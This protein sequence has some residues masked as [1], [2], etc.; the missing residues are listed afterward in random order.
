MGKTLPPKRTKGGVKSSHRFT[1]RQN[2]WAR[3]ARVTLQLVVLFFVFAFPAFAQA[4]LETLSQKISSGSVEQK[5]DAL[6]QLRNLHTEE[7]SRVAAPAVRDPN[8]MV[9]A[10]AA[11]SVI[12]LPKP[13]AVA[14]LLPLLKDKAPFVR[15]E[16]AFALG[17][18]GDPQN[19]QG[20]EKEDVIASALRLLLE[21]DKDP[22]V[23]AAAAVAMGK[24][25]GLKS[26]WYLYFFLQSSPKGTAN[27][28]IRRSAV[29]SIGTVAERLRANADILPAP[30]REIQ[31]EN[32]V[33]MDFSQGFRSFGS[34]SRLLTD[35]LQD[36]SEP[37]DVRREAAQALG[38]I[39][40]LS[41]AP[42]LTANLSA[43][44]PYLANVCK[45]ALQ[46][47][48]NIKPL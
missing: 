30:R 48:K 29:R 19:L 21:K 46:K 10:T 37:D 27:D 28:F 47:L 43:P 13:E 4:G 18:V 40:A 25:G 15:K 12:F 1:L 6:L 31:K 39:G 26:V 44:D 17:E 2:E 14:I 23:R 36:R 42:V 16:A 35:V 24:A 5:R 7:A 34:V 9:R 22:E 3:A 33:Q 11:S 32:Y 45:E 20:E 8:D 41:A 38:N